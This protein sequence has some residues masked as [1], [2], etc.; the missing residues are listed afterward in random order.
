MKEAIVPNYSLDMRGE[1]CPYPAIATLEA[2]PTL[3]KFYYLISNHLLSYQNDN[4][5]QIPMII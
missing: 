1:P 4:E 3:T 5:F 2:L